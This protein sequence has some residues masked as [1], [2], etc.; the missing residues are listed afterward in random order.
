M[1]E[2]ITSNSR[3][4]VLQLPSELNEHIG[5]LSKFNF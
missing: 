5:K 2:I 4:V 1:F 3:V